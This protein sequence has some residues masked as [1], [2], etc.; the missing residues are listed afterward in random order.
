MYMH[1]Q[2]YMHIITSCSLAICI[3]K[4]QTTIVII[5]LQRQDKCTQL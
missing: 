4:F 5:T 1:V 3:A 2:L